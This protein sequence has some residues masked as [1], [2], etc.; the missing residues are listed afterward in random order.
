MLVA[1]IFKAFAE[2]KNNTTDMDFVV[3]AAI[4]I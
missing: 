3:Q 2:T 1:D 4:E